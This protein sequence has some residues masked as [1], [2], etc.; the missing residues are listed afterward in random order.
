MSRE[1]IGSYLGL[2]I[3]TVSRTLSKMQEEGLISVQGRQI[4]LNDVS[5]LS[6]LVHQ[7]ARK[8]N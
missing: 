2:V 4:Q 3:E 8:A 6:A 1:D 7:P 5:A